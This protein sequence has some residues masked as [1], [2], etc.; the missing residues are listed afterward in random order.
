M[1]SYID[2]SDYSSESDSDYSSSDSDDTHYSD[3]DHEPSSA[4][5]S[6]DERDPKH[7]IDMG[8]GAYLKKLTGLINDKSIHEPKH[9]MGKGAL[10]KK[11]T[12]I[13]TSR[14]KGDK[15][16]TEQFFKGGNVIELDDT[17]IHNLSNPS[18]VMFFAPWCGH[19]Q[20]AKPM[21]E[22]VG[23]N[24]SKHN[25]KCYALNCEDHKKT[26]TKYNIKG[27]PTVGIVDND[28]M[29]H[30]Y[31]KERNEE[32]LTSWAM[33]YI[34]KPHESSK[35]KFF[36][37]GSVI[38]LDDK[39]IDKLS[40]NSTVMFFAPWCGP[41][42]NAKP[43]YEEVSELVSNKCYS[44]NCEDYKETGKRYGVTGYPTFA[45]VNNKSI[46][47]TYKG[48]RTVEDL[49]EWIEQ[50]TD[51]INSY[52]G[53]RDVQGMELELTPDLIKKVINNKEPSIVLFYSPQCGFCIKFKPTFIKVSKSVPRM[54]LVNCDLYPELSDKFVDIKNKPFEVTGFPTTVKINSDMVINVMTGNVSESV[55][56]KWIK[57]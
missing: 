29:L 44:L 10:L 43:I 27:Y 31:K 56:R 38:E 40:N 45:K 57:M 16:T 32:E 46:V 36:D 2:E 49:S 21:Y 13:I 12:G 41:C 4:E 7:K 53:K 47:D 25:I 26:S 33:E 20:N 50:D 6:E 19:C 17:S 52:T 8:K 9:T 3:S 23:Y 15:D 34:K 51:I 39:S 42:N 55:L 37:K 18:L 24:L 35:N 30:E 22:K 5:Q 14:N 48:K 1:S 28:K 54:Y 11:L